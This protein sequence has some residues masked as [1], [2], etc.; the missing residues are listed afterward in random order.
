VVKGVDFADKKSNKCLLSKRDEKD[1]I[2]IRIYVDDCLIIGNEAQIS[3]LIM[4][5]KNGGFN[6][7][8]KRNITELELSGN[9]ESMKQS[10]FN[11]VTCNQKFTW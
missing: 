7:K 9:D 4:D 8:V 3:R 6:H 5:L 2:L 1:V 11:P 10:N